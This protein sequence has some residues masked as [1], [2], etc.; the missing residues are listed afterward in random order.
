M[1]ALLLGDRIA[2]DVCS[3]YN[4]NQF[5]RY[6]SS[7]LA[8]G[9]YGDMLKDCENNR[10]M[11]PKRYQVAGNEMINMVGNVISHREQNMKFH[12]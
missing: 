10:W 12:R 2:L 1:E 9:Y 5:L 6:S 4:G 7:M 3:I 8:Y 11:G